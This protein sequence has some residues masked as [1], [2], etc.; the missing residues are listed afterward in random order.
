MYEFGTPEYKKL[1]PLDKRQPGSRAVIWVD[2]HKV[3]TVRIYLSIALQPFRAFTDCCFSFIFD[4]FELQSCGFSIPFFDY[5]RP[6]NKLH[7]IAAMQEQKDYDHSV[8]KD[9]G[10]SGSSN[11]PQ[12]LKH[13]WRNNNV[14][15]ID[16]LPGLEVAYTSSQPLGDWKNS[17]KVW[18][19]DDESIK[20]KSKENGGSAKV[21]SLVSTGQ[22]LGWDLG[23]VL[24]GFGAGLVVS[25]VISRFMKI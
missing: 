17:G 18:P 19:A 4:Q 15:S 20:S 2:V 5:N 22:G 6:R 23:K 3:G 14:K 10:P 24:V 7:R 21:I 16:G 13:W 11:G 8:Q 12:G 9:S 25:S 1:L